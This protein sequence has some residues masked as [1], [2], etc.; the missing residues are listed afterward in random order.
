MAASRPERGGAA[1]GEPNGVTAAYADVGAAL[2]RD[3][4]PCRTGGLPVRCWRIS[5]VPGAGAWAKAGVPISAANAAAITIVFMVSSTLTQ[6]FFDQEV[7]APAG[8][9]AACAIIQ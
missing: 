9:S 3:R 7:H 5:P 4:A 6:G 8:C 1:V 2:C